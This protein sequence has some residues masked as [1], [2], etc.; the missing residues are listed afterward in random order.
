MATGVPVD[1]AKKALSQAFQRRDVRGT[2]NA[3]LRFLS[4]EFYVRLPRHF[5][6][7]AVYSATTRRIA[8]T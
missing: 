2:L 1:A 7:F 8:G 3:T 4:H 6:V 5:D